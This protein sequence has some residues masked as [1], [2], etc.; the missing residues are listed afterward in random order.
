MCEYVSVVATTKGPLTFYA[1]PGLNSHG[2]ARA[3]WGLTEDSGAEV[4]WTGESYD[5]LS[6]R[7]EIP[8]TAKTIK[9]MVMDKFPNRSALLATITETRG[10]Q[11]SVAFYKN[12]IRVF[13]LTD[14]GPNFQEVNDLLE[15]LPSF[16]W[17]KP[18]QDLSEDILEQLV[19]EH[20]F[21][22]GK[23]NSNPNAFDGVTLK[24]VRTWEGFDAARV[25]AYDAAYDAAYGAAYGAA[26]GAARDAARGAAFDAACGAAYLISGLADNPFPSLVEIYALGCV[27]VGIVNEEFVVF[28]PPVS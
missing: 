8:E 7:H 16:P 28:I 3:G 1:S 5:Y 24:I 18:A 19:S 26:R 9:Q 14:G 2:D 11:N 23:R 6:V 20:L 10:P 21:N 13:T 22:L 4:E 17:M 25:A 15:K 12:G 27:P